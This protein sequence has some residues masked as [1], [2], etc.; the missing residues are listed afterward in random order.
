MNPIKIQEFKQI[1]NDFQWHE[2]LKLDKDQYLNFRNDLRNRAASRLSRSESVSR[3]QKGKVEEVIRDFKEANPT[4]PVSE[5]D[6][7]L[8]EWLALYCN[9]MVDQAK[10]KKIAE[11]KKHGL[12]PPPPKRKNV[13]PPKKHNSMDNNRTTTTESSQ[14]SEST[15]RVTPPSSTSSTDALLA[16]TPQVNAPTATETM[17]FTFST[18]ES[19]APV[20]TNISSTSEV[21]IPATTEFAVETPGIL[22]RHFIFSTNLLYSCIIQFAG[23]K[24]RGK[25]KKEVSQQKQTST[26][27]TRSSKKSKQ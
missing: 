27:Q 6:F 14:D 5:A 18:N 1:K 13:Q 26:R 7:I 11:A 25:R 3:Q 23:K 16:I 21:N 8:Q 17:V 15:S 10:K 2:L 24:G 22:A 19:N 20:V 12:P 4:F 9:S